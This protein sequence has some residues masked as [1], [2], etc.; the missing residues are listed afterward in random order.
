MDIKEYI[1]SGILESYVLGEVSPQEKQEVECM[2]SIYPEIK[3][4]LHRLEESIEN[5]A[6][7]NAIDPPSHMKDQVLNKLFQEIDKDLDEKL[8]EHD[9]TG[10][11]NLN[12]AK[13]D[14]KGTWK[15]MAAAFLALFLI[16]T[17]VFI[18]EQREN[19]ALTSEL[20]GLA[21]D[22]ENKNTQISELQN[23]LEGNL[24][25]N[26]ELLT[27]IADTNTVRVNL[28]GTQISTES[29]VNVFWNEIDESVV[30]KVNNLPSSPTDMQYQLW[31]I[32]DGQPKDMGV[33]PKDFNKEEFIR[34][35]KKTN[36]ASA[37]AITLEEEGGKPQPNLDQLYVI[38]NV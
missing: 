17:T 31:A 29:S 20:D 36:E 5:V 38:G 24:S 27:F 2:S 3:S 15:I 21:S 25:A 6:T 16:A 37:F 28:S 33:L 1:A 32:I 11:S 10:S 12:E 9:F 23:E 19:K 30:V 22:I 35:S 26:R 34:V 14:R 13:Q 4:A 18:N 8:I 7:E